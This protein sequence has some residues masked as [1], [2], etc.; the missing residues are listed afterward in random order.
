MSG[1]VDRERDPCGRDRALAGATSQFPAIWIVT[2]RSIED[3]DILRARKGVFAE[4][5]VLRGQ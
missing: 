4:D 1:V 2:N 3:D 5:S